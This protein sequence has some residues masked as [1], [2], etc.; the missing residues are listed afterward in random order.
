MNEEFEEVLWQ[1]DDPVEV[2]ML[3]NLVTDWEN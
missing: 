1:T 3:L 2:L